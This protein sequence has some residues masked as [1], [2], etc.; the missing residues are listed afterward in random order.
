MSSYGNLYNGTFSSSIGSNI[1]LPNTLQVNKY[2]NSGTKG[3]SKQGMDSTYGLVL[4]TLNAGTGL[5][6]AYLGYRNYGLAKDQFN[7]SKNAMNRDI[8]NQGKLINNDIMNRAEVGLALASKELTDTDR[9][10]ILSNAKN[11]FVDTTP[12]G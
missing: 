10:R 7:F 12:I 9:S 8:A 4:G 3:S 11:K 5:A 6:N 2:L 1:K